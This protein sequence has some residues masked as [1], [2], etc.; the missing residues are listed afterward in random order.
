MSRKRGK[1][2]DAAQ[3]RAFGRMIRGYATRER[4]SRNAA[5]ALLPAVIHWT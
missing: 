4:K 3:D 1:R 5:P 2:S